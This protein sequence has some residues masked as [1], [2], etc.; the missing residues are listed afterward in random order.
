M[1][2]SAYVDQQAGAYIRN[3]YYHWFVMVPSKN[4]AQGFHTKD[5][6]QH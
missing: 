2:Y 1:A 3:N 4:I 5:E 6:F